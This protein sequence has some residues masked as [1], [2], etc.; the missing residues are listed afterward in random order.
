MAAR[1]LLVPESEGFSSD[2]EWAGVGTQTLSFIEG[3]RFGSN[4]Q[5]DT[6]S[7]LEHDIN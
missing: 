2:L 3:Y 4:E 7:V 6:A 5:Y 1:L